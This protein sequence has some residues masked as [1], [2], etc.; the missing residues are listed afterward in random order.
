MPENTAERIRGSLL[1]GAV[2]DALG[3]PVE[4]MSLSQIRTKFGPLGLS[5]YQNGYDGK[6]SI[7]DDTQMTL[8][9]AEG[10]ILSQVRQEYQ[11]PD[12]VPLAV[13]H[14]Y[15]RWLYTQEKAMENSLIKGFGT[16]AIVDGALTVH[17]QLFSRRAPGN[18]CLS[19]LESGKMGTMTDPINQSKGCGGVMRMAPVGLFCRDAGEAFQLGCECAAIT[20]GHPSGYIS[21]GFLA[22]LIALIV[23]DKTLTE[24]IDGSI[25]ILQTF[26]RHEEVF[27]AVNRALE[28]SRSATPATTAI[29]RL[30][31]GWVAEEALAIGIYCALTAD[32]DFP[33]GVLAAV[34]HD[35]D[36]DSTAAITGNIIGALHGTKVI[37]TD[38]MSGLELKEVIAE[39]AEDLFN[40][41][42]A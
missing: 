4:F 7:T 40:C 35:G 19:A 27:K 38:W 39:I 13:F 8:F 34:N 14:A 29:G 15:L 17:P 25:Q 33:K 36:S 30:G 32:N 37:P 5:D 41:T 24:A 6:G 21:A 22:A 23:S 9:T 20:H 42:T 10:L 1:G 16:C 3:A 11:A 18:S 26:P 31:S 28:L 12:K 2:G